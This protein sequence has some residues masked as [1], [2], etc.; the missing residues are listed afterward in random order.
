[1]HLWKGIEY[2]IICLNALDKQFTKC[3]IFD[4]RTPVSHYR[5]YKI[6]PSQKKWMWNGIFAVQFRDKLIT[7]WHEFSFFSIVLYFDLTIDSYLVLVSIG[8]CSTVFNRIDYFFIHFQIVAIPIIIVCMSSDYEN[9][10]NFFFFV[11]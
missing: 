9:W 1:M 2:H 4:F 7:L 11:V 6:V 5:W 10:R 3:S 8:S